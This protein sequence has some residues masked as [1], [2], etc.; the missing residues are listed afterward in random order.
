MTIKYHDEVVQG[1]D[2]W[3]ALRCGILTASEMDK[4]LT[5]ATLQV[6]NNDETRAHLFEL[7]AQRVNKYVEPTY[8]GDDMIRGHAD[9]VRARIAYSEK[10]SEVT[11]V[12]FVTNDRFGFTLGYSPD[13]LVG[14]DGQIECKSRK[15]KYQIETLLSK[16]M[17][18]NKKINCM[19]QVQTGLMVTERKW[20]DFISYH[21]GMPMMTYRI[22]PDEE[23]QKAIFGAA[24]K[25][26]ER[27]REKL[28]EY[29]AV[30]SDPEMR[31]IPTERVIEEEI[32][33]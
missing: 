15:Q 32:I 10:Y 6:A 27:I 29:N 22:Y 12:G 23:I 30:L 14:D 5:P 13:G 26:E 4:I 16:G 7:L 11:E 25:F 21:G 17:P 3:F 31:L 2:E 19:L 18:T 20:C 24:Q 33:V 9:E 8:I 28:D 1:S